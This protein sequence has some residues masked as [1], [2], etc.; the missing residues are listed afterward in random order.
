LLP[1]AKPRVK[2]SINEI[3]RPFASIKSIP[4]AA[5]ALDKVIRKEISEAA[6]ENVT[7][8]CGCCRHALFD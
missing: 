5:N 4:F 1:A 6:E 7:T 3:S 2:F 8:I